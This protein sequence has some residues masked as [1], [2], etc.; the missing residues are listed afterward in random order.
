MRYVLAPLLLALIGLAGCGSDSPA[1]TAS[2]T[3]DTVAEQTPTT[4][5]Q[6]PSNSNSN[7]PPKTTKPDGAYIG[8]WKTMV[9]KHQA[10]AAGDPYSA[11]PAT[12]V[13]NTDGTFLL[14]SKDAGRDPGAYGA[15]GSNLVFSKD[16]A[17]KDFAGFGVY[18]WKVSGHSLNLSLKRPETGGCTGRS[19]SLTIPTWHRA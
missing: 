1:T 18:A 11:G 10:I 3:A 14:T 6:T 7:Q 2:T 17:C 16:K 5:T 19:D 9:T 4:T 12:L 8:T 13:L 15:A